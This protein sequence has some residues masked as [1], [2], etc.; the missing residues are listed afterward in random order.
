MSTSN[1]ASF[2]KLYEIAPIML[3]G[4]IASGLPDSMMNILQLTEGDQNANYDDPNQ[5]F[6]HYKVLSGS[7]LQDWGIAEYPFASMIMAANAVIKNPLKVSLL[8]ACPAQT[9]VPT[10]LIQRQATINR[11]KSSL[12]DHISQGGYFIVSTPGFTYSNC[13]LTALHDIT[14]PTEKQVQFLYQWD[15]VQPLITQSQA[16][17]TLNAL[18]NKL[19]KG[20]PTQDLNNSGLS[21]VV[22]NPAT[23][24]PQPSPPTP[25]N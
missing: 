10:N 24:Q 20:L 25:T 7:S 16:Q 18:Y 11:L 23:N 21:N 15:F 22:N 6:A 13:L 1:F 14:N 4:G 9:K 17:I 8:M 3:V 2:Q 19:D 12:D 5:Y